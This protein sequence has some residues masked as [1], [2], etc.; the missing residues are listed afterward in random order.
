V[1]QPCWVVVVESLRVCGAGWFSSER[2]LKGVD[3]DN[4]AGDR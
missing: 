1:R 4:L 3:V 2:S